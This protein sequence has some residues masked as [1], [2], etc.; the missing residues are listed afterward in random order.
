MS[1]TPDRHA[2]REE[3][4]ELDPDQLTED[5]LRYF[6][7]PPGDADSPTSDADAPPPG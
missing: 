2:A 6:D 1:D 5:A 4:A 7:E 3:Y